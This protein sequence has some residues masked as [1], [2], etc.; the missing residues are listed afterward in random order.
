MIWETEPDTVKLL[1]TAQNVS[2]KEFNGISPQFYADCI[3]LPLVNKQ[4]AELNNNN[5][6]AYL[7][8]LAILL[9]MYKTMKDIRNRVNHAVDNP[10]KQNA[11]V[12]S[13][14]F[15]IDLATLVYQ[16]AVRK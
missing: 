16:D 5:A 6:K 9:F 15:F 14:Y 7:K 8:N 2:L 3:T 11:I 13:I 4:E 10:Y 1:K 12:N